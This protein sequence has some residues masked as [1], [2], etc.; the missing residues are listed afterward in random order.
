MASGHLRPQVNVPS[1]GIA[2]PL[3][4]LEN[5]QSLKIESYG[6][7]EKEKTESPDLFSL[8]LPRTTWGPELTT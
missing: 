7:V 2:Y 4:A 3:A 6:I 1:G 5:Y 8:Q